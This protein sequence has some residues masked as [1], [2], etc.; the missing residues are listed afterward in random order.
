MNLC[1]EAFIDISEWWPV[2]ADG[3]LLSVYAVHREI[4][5]TP[6]EVTRHTLTRA[7][8]GQL[9]KGDF[10]NQVKLAR[11]CSLW[12]DRTVTIDEIVKVYDDY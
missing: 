3:K 2:G 7:R 11:I 9:A 4:E 6:N 1:M 5:G 10:A 8:D 12:A